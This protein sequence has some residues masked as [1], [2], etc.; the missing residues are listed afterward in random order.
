VPEKAGNMTYQGLDA[1]IS[2]YWPENQAFLPE[3]ADNMT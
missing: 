2:P 3:K 1:V